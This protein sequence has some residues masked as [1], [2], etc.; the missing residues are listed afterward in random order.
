MIGR[1]SEI[2]IQYQVYDVDGNEID[3][4]VGMEP[5][6]F[7]IGEHFILPVLEEALVGHVEGDV[8]DITLTPGEAYG[9]L[10]PDAY[11]EIPLESIPDDLREEGQIVG[12]AD[13]DDR[14]YQVTIIKIEDDKAII[15][16][17]H[18]L[19]G[20]TLRFVIKVLEVK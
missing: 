1:G 20:E 16:L 11:R 7:A 8:K 2:S 19:A 3:G 9:E 17:N 4:N 15:D 6:S 12:L 14:Q 10:I 13:E 18:P 5:L